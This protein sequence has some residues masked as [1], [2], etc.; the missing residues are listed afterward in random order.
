MSAGMHDMTISIASPNGK[1]SLSPR[2]DNP[3]QPHIKLSYKSG[4]LKTAWV[5]TLQLLMISAQT[6]TYRMIIHRKIYSCNARESYVDINHVGYHVRTY[7][8]IRSHP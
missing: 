1:V 6:S 4:E 2:S 5:K 3:D 7:K 8:S